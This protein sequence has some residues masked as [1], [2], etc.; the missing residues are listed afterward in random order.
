MIP[1]AGITKGKTIAN[2]HNAGVIIGRTNVQQI[3]FDDED[4]HIP[5]EK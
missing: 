1:P 4:I 5:L 2:K 3:V